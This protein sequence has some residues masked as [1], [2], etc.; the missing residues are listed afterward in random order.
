MSCMDPSYA[1]FV[2]SMQ[3][4]YAF[5]ETSKVYTCSPGKKSILQ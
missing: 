3:D 5:S 2:I 1:L 4:V